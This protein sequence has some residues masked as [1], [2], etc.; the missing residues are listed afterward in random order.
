MEVENI[1]MLTVPWH[2]WFAICDILHISLIVGAYWCE[3][4]YFIKLIYITMTSP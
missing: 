3:G 2:R 4:A 1:L